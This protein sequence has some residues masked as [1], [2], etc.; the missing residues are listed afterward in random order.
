M[1]QVLPWLVGGI[2]LGVIVFFLLNMTV[3]SQKFNSSAECGESTYWDYCIEGMM[4]HTKCN[5]CSCLQPTC[6]QDE[7]CFTYMEETS[8]IESVDTEVPVDQTPPAP[9]SF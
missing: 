6:Q 9:P 2:A 3:P 5:L 1:K 7:H 4:C 8:P